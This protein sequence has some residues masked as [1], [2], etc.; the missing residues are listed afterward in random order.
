MV[1]T[2]CW[3]TLCLTKTVRLLLWHQVS[4]PFLEPAYLASNPDSTLNDVYK[5]VVFLSVPQLSSLK[6]EMIMVFIYKEL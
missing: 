2:S 4:S 3:L 5:Q 6:N 1:L